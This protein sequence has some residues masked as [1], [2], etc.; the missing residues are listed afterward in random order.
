MKKGK[1]TCV[2]SPRV[3]KRWPGCD[4]WYAPCGNH[5][6][7]NCLTPNANLNISGA[8]MPTGSSS[9][10]HPVLIVR[11]QSD[12]LYQTAKQYL[13]FYNW[14]LLVRAFSYSQLF[15]ILLK[16]FQ[17]LILSSVWFCIRTYSSSLRLYKE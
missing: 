2:Q 5:F 8:C 9:K 6:L 17:F 1:S 11:K 3:F 16:R 14:I 12:A 4:R 15:E 13:P 10:Q 7:R